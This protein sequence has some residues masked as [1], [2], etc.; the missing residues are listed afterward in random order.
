[1]HNVEVL[2]KGKQRCTLQ[3]TPPTP[4]AS[5]W[6][7]VA[8]RPCAVASDSVEAPVEVTDAIA[9]G[10]VSLPHGWGHDAPGSRLDVASRRPGVNTNALTDGSI[11]DPLSGNGLLNAI[12]VEVAPA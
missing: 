10:S 9:P 7:T 8:V 2:V 5:A 3:S 1:M 4:T 12:P 6:S 11:V